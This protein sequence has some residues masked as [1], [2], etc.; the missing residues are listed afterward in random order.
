MAQFSLSYTLA[1]AFARGDLTPAAYEGDVLQGSAITAL[2]QLIQIQPVAA[3]GENGQRRA[4]LGKDRT[5]RLIQDILHGPGDQ[6]VHTLLQ[7]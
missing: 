4:R 6:P 3:F 7:N 2:E 1:Y 5:A